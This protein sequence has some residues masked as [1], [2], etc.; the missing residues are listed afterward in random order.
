MKDN[1]DKNANTSISSVIPEWH[2]KLVC[3][4]LESY[5]NNPDSLKNF[6]ETITHL[7]RCIHPNNYLTKECIT[8]ILS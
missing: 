8:G 5:K 4:R 7:G 6:L 1:F 2:K 3:E